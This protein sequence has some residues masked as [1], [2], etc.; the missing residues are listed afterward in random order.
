MA[1]GARAHSPCQP[2]RARHSLGN[3]QD[4][5]SSWPTEPGKK[6]SG[7]SSWRIPLKGLEGLP[8]PESSGD[9]STPPCTPHP[10]AQFED[11]PLS[12]F[13]WKR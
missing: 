6:G 10:Y 7:H 2:P 5:N 4:G 1:A 13:L 3:T 8:S 12:G 11:V 9:R